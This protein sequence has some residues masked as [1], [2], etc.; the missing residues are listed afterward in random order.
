MIGDVESE[1]GLRLV[2]FSPHTGT[3]VLCPPVCFSAH[4]KSD[5]VV[6]FS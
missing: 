6:F 3:T 4:L 5:G 1:S 2:G